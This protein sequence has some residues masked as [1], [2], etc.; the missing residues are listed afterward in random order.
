MVESVT[1]GI[2]LKKIRPA[3]SILALADKAPGYEDV[4]WA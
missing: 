3:P 2:L 4:N 1:L